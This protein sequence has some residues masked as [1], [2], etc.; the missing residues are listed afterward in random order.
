MELDLN[1]EPLD[2]TP[3]SVIGFDSILDELESTHDHIEERIRQ[4]EAVTLRARQ[5]QRWR[6]GHDSVQIN[7]IVADMMM[8]PSAQDEH[9][10]PQ[11]Y[12]GIAVQEQTVVLAELTRTNAQNE[13]RLA[14]EEA[15]AVQERTVNNRKTGKRNSS[16]LV[17]QALGMDPYIDETVSTTG[18]FF[19]CNICLD[20]ARDPILTCCGHL[21]CWPCFYQVSFDY[22]NV[23]ECPVCKGEVAETGIIPIYGSKN[24]SSNHELELKESGFT[25]PPR[26]QAPRIESLRQQLISRGAS[27]STIQELRRFIG[28][29]A[30]DRT[31][32]S[33]NQPHHSQPQ[34]LHGMETR[35]RQPNRSRLLSRLLVEGAASFSSLSSALNSAMDSAERL[36][37][38][39]EAYIHPQQPQPI[40]SSRELL[41][42]LPHNRDSP[43][44]IAA[45]NQ[46]GRLIPDVAASNSAANASL[47]P[48]HMNNDATAVIDSGIQTTDSS[49]QI[50]ST[51]PSSSSSRTV[52]TGLPDLYNRVSNGRRRR[53][54]RR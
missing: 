51:E 12:G 43:S 16:H 13:G 25:V 2:Q 28:A 40:G 44:S 50:S 38:D 24:N 53:R 6:R 33:V 3:T 19:D 41:H 27:S 7:N 34:A 26:P 37:G 49:V 15:G 11:E 8:V 42:P 14:S 1:E 52:V 9:R 17:A 45:T 20:M 30:T 4:L 54:L 47:S 23:R 22:S 5:R 18:N 39:L 48:L 32:F 21:F 10:M 29:A 36:V 46:S 31:R 35:V